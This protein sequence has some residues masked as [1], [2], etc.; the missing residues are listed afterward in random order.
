VNLLETKDGKEYMKKTE[1]CSSMEEIRQCIDEIDKN[2][3]MDLALRST[4]VKR[5]AIFKKTLTDVKA[6]QR[7]K[8]M[9]S[10]RRRWAAENGMDPDF[11]ESIFRSIVGHFIGNEAQEWDRKNATIV[12]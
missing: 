3:L 1:E 9:I 11:I 8:T 6:D 4:F 10:A 2:I 5:A 7:V 12:S